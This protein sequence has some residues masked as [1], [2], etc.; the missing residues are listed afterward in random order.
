MRAAWF[1]E[2]AIRVFTMKVRCTGRHIPPHKLFMLIPLGLPWSSSWS[3]HQLLTQSLRR[4]SST[5]RRPQTHTSFPL[6]CVGFWKRTMSAASWRMKLTNY[7]DSLTIGSPSPRAYGTS[8]FGSKESGQSYN[9]ARLLFFSV[10]VSYTF[11]FLIC[12]HD[13]FLLFLCVVPALDNRS[14]HSPR[15]SRYQS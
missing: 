10:L 13:I 3:H 1:R 15:A 7:C 14:K 8:S 4:T 6:R 11:F 5:V 9:G 12:V 2:R